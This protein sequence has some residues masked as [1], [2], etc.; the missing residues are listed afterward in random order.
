MPK[1]INL[2]LTI[3]EQLEQYLQRKYPTKTTREALRDFLVE[4][5]T[6]VE[7]PI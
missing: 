2:T 7:L 6:E 5:L 4:I 3:D 1:P